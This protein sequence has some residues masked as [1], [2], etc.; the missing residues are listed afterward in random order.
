MYKTN[1]FDLLEG[2]GW[3]TSLWESKFVSLAG[4][5]FGRRDVMVTGA[6]ASVLE[7][8]R[9]TSECPFQISRANQKHLAQPREALVN[10]ITFD[11]SRASATGLHH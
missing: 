6:C 11:N 3:E 2:L 4:S 5:F 9:S 8:T 7:R 1:C 10:R